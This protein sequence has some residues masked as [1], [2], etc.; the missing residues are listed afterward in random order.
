M[1]DQLLDA[2]RPGFF[3]VDN[4]L[5]DNFGPKIGVYGVAVY[6]LLARFAGSGDAS[7]PSYQTIASKLGMSRFQAIKTVKTLIETS[8]ITCSPRTNQTGD[9]TSNVYTLVDLKGSQS[10]RPPVV[11]QVDHPSQSGRPPVVNHVDPK[12]KQLEEDLLTKTQGKR[13]RESDPVVAPQPPPSEPLPALPPAVAHPIRL[14][15]PAPP[16]EEQMAAKRTEPPVSVKAVKYKP[17]AYTKGPYLAGVKLVGGY[18]A[19]NTGV[20][21]VQVYHERHS[22][23]NR[24]LQLTAPQQDDLVKAIDDLERWRAVV[25]AWNQAGHKPRNIAGH[26]DWYRDGIPTVG[27]P[28]VTNGRREFGILSK[29]PSFNGQPTDSSST[30]SSSTVTPEQAAYFR[31]RFKANAKQR[32][33]E[34]AE[35][36][37]REGR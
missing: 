25:I 35:Q 21:A 16:T 31:E 9:A 1:G 27:R 29:E 26:L 36:Q 20:N 23:E 10:G 5:I 14:D 37:A 6:S 17:T 19:P 22:A 3:I 33:A 7:F 15:E 18:V 28:D 34:F 24:D 30:V 12:K 4:E 32:A 2:R 8:L 13:G 11:N